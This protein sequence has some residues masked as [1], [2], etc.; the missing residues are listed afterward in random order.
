M[1][2]KWSEV[3]ADCRFCVAY[4][5]VYADQQAIKRTRSTNDDSSTNWS[6]PDDRHR[7]TTSP[8]CLVTALLRRILHSRLI[9]QPVVVLR[10]RT[11]WVSFPRGSDQFRDEIPIAVTLTSAG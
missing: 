5:N 7:V 3:T 10:L 9:R 6:H 11:E 8:L 1:A 4:E 2:L